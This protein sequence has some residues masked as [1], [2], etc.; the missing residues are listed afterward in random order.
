LTFQ[1]SGSTPYAIGVSSG[2]LTLSGN[3]TDT[4]SNSLGGGSIDGSVTLTGSSPTV[5]VGNNLSFIGSNTL[6]TGSN[7]VTFTGAGTLDNDIAISGSG[8]LDIDMSSGTFHQVVTASPGFTGQ[9]NLQAGTLEDHSNASPFTDLFSAASDIAVSSGATLY[10]VDGN[11]TGAT[12]TEPLTIGGDGV[13]DCT[14]VFND[15]TEDCGAIEDG[16]QPGGTLTLAGAMTL[17]ANAQLN[18]DDPSDIIAITGALSGDFTA[19]NATATLVVN[20][21]DN[22]SGTPNG[23][24]AASGNLQSGNGSSGAGLPKAGGLRSPLNLGFLAVLAMLGAGFAIGGYNEYR[25]RHNQS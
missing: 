13:G 21:S 3:I 17:T 10:F 9:I 24:Y 14:D 16:L 2:A 5:S 18:S 1:G 25:H 4:T 11:A 8:T 6:T 20:S 7:T 15:V 23:T 22:T 12:I 19:Q